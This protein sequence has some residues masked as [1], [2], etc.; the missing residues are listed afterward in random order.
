MNPFL[1]YDVVDVT[2]VRYTGF[3]GLRL[4][5]DIVRCLP[6]CSLAL[7]SLSKQWTGGPLACQ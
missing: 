1:V 5:F 2:R 6:A 4:G 7:P 3:L